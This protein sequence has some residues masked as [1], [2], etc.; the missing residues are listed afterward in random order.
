MKHVINVILIILFLS[1]GV[2]CAQ[3]GSV[4][5]Q[6]L[7]V[8]GYTVDVVYI[9]LTDPNIRITPVVSRNFPDSPEK[10]E[11][12]VKREQPLAAINGNFFCKNTYKPVGDIVING[13]LVNF[14]G[15]GTAMA[16]DRNNKVEFIKVDRYHHMNW[17]PYKA[18]ISCG[19]Q[20]L[21]D[22]KVVVDARAEGFQDPSLFGARNRSAV[23][24]TW[25]N[26]LALVTIPSGIYFS[27]LAYVMKDLGCTDAMN[28][29]GGGSMGM[30]YK[31][32][33]VSTPRT[34]LPD[35]LVVKENDMA[36]DLLISLADMMSMKEKKIE[37]FSSVSM[38]V[39]EDRVE[40]KGVKD[41]KVY[42]FMKFDKPGEIEVPPIGGSF[43]TK[44]NSVSFKMPL[45]KIQGLLN[46]ILPSE[47]AGS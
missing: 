3:T 29:D 8:R 25:D 46:Q 39:K 47:K 44:D 43:E 34:D 19:P 15:L 9:D 21:E 11:T 32:Q 14:G 26:K 12:M 13:E 31:G 23:G 38:T 5:Y 45:E 10:F 16:I 36:S 27:D 22:G 40:I 1:I 30:Y 20:L 35:I 17:A 37:V 4:N 18:V 24:V 7:S 42:L 28:L 6:H 41:N 2:A 33:V